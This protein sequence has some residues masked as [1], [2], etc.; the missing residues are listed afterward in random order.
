MID[1]EKDL[2]NNQNIYL[3]K[4]ANNLTVIQM[5]VQN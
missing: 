5:Q 1:L 4:K 2:S 3:L